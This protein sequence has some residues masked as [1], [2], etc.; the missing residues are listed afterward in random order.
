MSH[1]MPA[2]AQ[3]LSEARGQRRLWFGLFGGPV[4]WSVQELATYAL[5]ASACNPPGLRG[6]VPRMPG[7]RAWELIV[8]VVVLAVAIGAAWTAVRGWHAARP[9]HGSAEGLQL[10]V[11]EG[12]V[13]FMAFAGI[14]LSAIFLFGI[15]M[16][17][18]SIFMV[19]PCK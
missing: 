15:V 16:N 8:G 3:S 6:G 19:P 5:S 2:P 18:V 10:E 13:G 14:L 9:A 7:L 12:R 11:G 4:A 17:L 1:T